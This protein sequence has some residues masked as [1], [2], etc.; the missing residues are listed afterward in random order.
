TISPPCRHLE[1]PQRKC[2]RIPKLTCSSRVMTTARSA[3]F[4]WIGSYAR[5]EI[6]CPRE[7]RARSAMSS[8]GSPLEPQSILFPRPSFLHRND[9]LLA[10]VRE[11]LC[12]AAGLKMSLEVLT[13][14]VQGV[15]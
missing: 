1:L 10:D 13:E 8:K 4:G 5:A 15:Q 9:D 7:S 12:R 6:P 14:P 3:R 2:L 11:R